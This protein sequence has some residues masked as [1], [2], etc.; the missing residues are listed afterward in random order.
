VPFCWANAPPVATTTTA[1]ASKRLFIFM[2]AA[3]P[4]DKCR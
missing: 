3:Y 1:V 4:F 2:A